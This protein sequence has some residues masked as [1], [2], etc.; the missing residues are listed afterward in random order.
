MRVNARAGG[1]RAGLHRVE[2]A[3]RN[4]K[5]NGPHMAGRE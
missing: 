3:A 2:K 5:R 4:L 1:R